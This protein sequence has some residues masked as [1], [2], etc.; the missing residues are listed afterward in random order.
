MLV[1]L[2]SELQPSRLFLCTDSVGKE[3]VFVMLSKYY[4]TRVVVSR[5]RWTY[6]A[7]MDFDHELYFTTDLSESWIEVI[8]K[9][10]KEERIGKTKGAIAV[11]LTGW[12]NLDHPYPDGY[13]SYL[14]PYSLHSN[15]REMEM[16][17]SWVRPKKLMGVVKESNGRW[18]KFGKGSNYSGYVYSLFGIK[19]RGMAFL[20]E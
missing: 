18:D 16:L 4:K 20:R 7:A 14:L 13:N 1:N 3:E 17:V 12:A 9:A 8:P 10:E 15:F 5:N 11:T 19:Q 2:V 6:I